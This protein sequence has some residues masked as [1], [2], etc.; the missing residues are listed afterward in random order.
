MGEGNGDAAI[1][2]FNVS[3]RHNVVENNKQKPLKGKKKF[4]EDDMLQAKAKNEQ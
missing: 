1:M 3:C 2:T 4:M